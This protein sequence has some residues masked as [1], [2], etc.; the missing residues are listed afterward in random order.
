M[1][2]AVDKSLKTKEL[3]DGHRVQP[4]GQSRT[5]QIEKNQQ[6]EATS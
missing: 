5:T 6:F 3:S 2:A 4:V 1:T